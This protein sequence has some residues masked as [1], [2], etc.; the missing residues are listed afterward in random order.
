V[1]SWEEYLEKG[2]LPTTF[3]NLCKQIEVNKETLCWE[4]QGY[5]HS[6]GYGMAP[7]PLR[8]GKSMR[9][10]RLMWTITQKSV[11]AETMMVCHKCDNRRCVNPAHLFLGTAKM[12]YDDMVAK[13]RAAARKYEMSEAQAVKALK[14]FKQGYK[15]REVSKLLSVRVQL[16]YWLRAL[17]SYKHLTR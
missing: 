12:N 14:L 9:A 15:P 17:K 7:H 11:P 16:L 6:S 5:R 4:W 2:D 1:K 10:H 8:K 13:G 3:S